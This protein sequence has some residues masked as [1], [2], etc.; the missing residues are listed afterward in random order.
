MY[1]FHQPQARGYRCIITEANNS[2]AYGAVILD[3][4]STSGNPV[5]AF[6]EVQNGGE[7]EE[8]AS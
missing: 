5:E 4:R 2:P 8:V 1:I 6:N 3:Y 7:D